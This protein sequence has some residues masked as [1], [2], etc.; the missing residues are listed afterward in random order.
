[1]S[2]A[3]VEGHT[4]LS[5]GHALSRFKVLARHLDSENAWTLL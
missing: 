5:Y 2:L 1:M 3:N 4:V